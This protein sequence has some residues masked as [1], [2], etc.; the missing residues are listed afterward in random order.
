MFSLGTGQHNDIVRVKRR[1]LGTYD[2]SPPPPRPPRDQ[3]VRR[4]RLLGL[5]EVPVGD[6]AVAVL[7]ES[8][9]ESEEPE[10]ESELES[11]LEVVSSTAFC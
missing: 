8:E 10:L 11:E 2:Q 6:T 3:P 4:F 5:V 9:P 1:D 7:V